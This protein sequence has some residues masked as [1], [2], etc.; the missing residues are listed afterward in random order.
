[1]ELTFAFH[2]TQK[3]FFLAFYK[4]FILLFHIILEIRYF[5]NVLLTKFHL[6][7]WFKYL[8][9]I[10]SSCGSQNLKQ[11]A[12]LYWHPVL[13]AEVDHLNFLKIVLL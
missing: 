11:M 1:M 3:T 7:S 8:F 4:L 13:L 9:T 12:G 5:T 6:G 10:C 2:C